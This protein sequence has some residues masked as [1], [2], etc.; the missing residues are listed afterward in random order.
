MVDDYLDFEVVPPRRRRQISW[1]K[2]G[3]LLALVVSMAW[4]CWNWYRP[5]HIGAVSAASSDSGAIAVPGPDL[6]KLPARVGHLIYWAGPRAGFTYEVRIS[7]KS[8]Y[9]R[10]LPTGAKLGAPLPYLTLGT[11]E[12]VGAYAGLTASAAMAGAR[13]LKLPGGSLLVTPAN[14]PN[15]AY[16]AFPGSN[17]LMEVFDPIPGAAFDLVTSGAVQP[18]GG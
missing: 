1:A 3:V 18:I 4:P 17:L 5:N 13:A 11:Y 2:V 15:S 9:L 8:V 12:S 16:F 6:V 10:Y 7:G 14:H